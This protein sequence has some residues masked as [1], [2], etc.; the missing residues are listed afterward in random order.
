[1][2]RLALALVVAAAATACGRG[3][4]D[5]PSPL[6]THPSVLQGTLARQGATAQALRLE[7]TASHDTAAQYRVTG[8]GTL[9]AD[10]VTVTGT[11]MGGSACTYLQSQDVSP[12]PF[13]PESARLTLQRSGGDALTLLCL[14]RESAPNWT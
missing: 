13:L 12:P 4:V 2:K 3:T 10:A 9:G 1:M 14:S 7:L 6:A 8:T 11:V 5:S